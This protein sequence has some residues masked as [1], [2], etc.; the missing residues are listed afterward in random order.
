[1]YIIYLILYQNECKNVA[2][3]YSLSLPQKHPETHAHK[4]LH[5]ALNKDEKQQ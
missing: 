2:E 4:A 5:F 3:K 1:M